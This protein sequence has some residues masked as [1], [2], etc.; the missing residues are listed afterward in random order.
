MYQI[1]SSNQGSA[2]PLDNTGPSGS[3][4]HSSVCSR[5]PLTIRNWRRRDPAFSSAD[6][7]RA[8][9]SIRC[10]SYDGRPTEGSNKDK[11]PNW[12]YYRFYHKINTNRV[13][14]F[15]GEELSQ[16]QWTRAFA[17]YV[18]LLLCGQ[19]FEFLSWYYE[20]FPL[21]DKLT[22]EACGDVAECLFLDNH[23]GQ[24]GMGQAIARARRRFES[25]L[26]NVDPDAMPPLS[27]Q[28]QP[29]DELCSSLL[30]LPQFTSKYFFFII[31]EF[32]VL[33]YQQKVVNTLI[34]HCGPYYTFKIGIKELGWRHKSTLNENEQLISPADYERIDIGERLEGDNFARFAR[35]VCKLRVRATPIF[36]DDVDIEQLFPGLSFDAE[37]ELLEIA[38]Q[39]PRIQG[40]AVQ[41]GIDLSDFRQLT[42]LE[43][44]FVD[45][46]RPT[47]V[48]VC[49]RFSMRDLLTRA[50]GL[51]ATITTRLRSCSQ[52]E[53]EKRESES[54][55]QAGA[56]TFFLQTVTFDIC[57]N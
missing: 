45:P 46:G 25:F 55:T 11:V 37:A 42:S 28:G 53:Q 35:D 31:D 22:E 12:P 54:I 16:E 23:L 47:L 38:D 41:E 40:A 50:D 44:L 24:G 48:A 26:N 39:L 27:M 7:E 21:A 20:L 1:L 8:R 6:A 19:I 29:I 18:N 32:K 13:T 15:F 34:K 5:N 30:K 52:L 10:L 3:I 33:G 4:R 2:V 49:V 56:L 43:Q 36:P 9:H 57:W 14:A 51:S 17:H